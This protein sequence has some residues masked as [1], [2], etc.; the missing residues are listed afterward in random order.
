M[1]FAVLGANALAFKADAI[2]PSDDPGQAWETLLAQSAPVPA[3]SAATVAPPAEPATARR[4]RARRAPSAD[5][6]WGARRERFAQMQETGFNLM[7]GGVA[8]GVGGVA[9]M[10][11]GINRME[12]SHNSDPYGNDTG[13]PDG[14]LPFFIGYIS[15]VAG[16]PALM[17]TGIILN[18]IGNHK[19]QQA[20]EMLGT[21]SG[22]RLDLG[23]NSLKLSYS[24]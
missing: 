22:A 13:S 5:I 3:E 21:D 15:V 16:L 17:T 12:G 11:Y 10:V 24:F 6:D 23:P 9:L 7:M 4:P 14:I 1:I 19:R 2:A 8:C 20:E 18:R